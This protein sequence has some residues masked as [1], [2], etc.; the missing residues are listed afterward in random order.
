MDRYVTG[1][2]IRR[3]REEKGMTQAEL[4]GLLCVSD[5]AISKWETGRGL[6]DISLI[7]PL[8]E[9]L[10]ISVG[11]LL[12]GEP[13]VNRNL[14]SNMLRGSFYVCPLCGNVIHAV[15]R[16]AISCCGIALPPLEADAPDDAHTFDIQN[17][18]DE[19]YITIRHD[20]TK[21]HFISFLAFVS[22]DRVQLVKLYPEGEAGTRLKLRGS[23]Y[24]YCYCNRHGL[25]RQKI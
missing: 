2:T 13:V 14:S 17:V 3:L 18:E 10:G 5:K 25:M 20:M 12:S 16:A 8:A 19:H 11:E 7:R 15:G 24:L 21:T 9:G 4:A 22:T 23:G 6:P 1:A